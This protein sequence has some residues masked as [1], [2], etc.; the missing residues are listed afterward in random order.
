MR[1]RTGRAG[2][3]VAH[4]LPGYRFA[5]EVL[6]RDV[7]I[8]T[9]AHL[10]LEDLLNVARVSTSLRSVVVGE[11]GAWAL[12]IEDLAYHAPQHA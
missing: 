2:E 5:L 4:G 9:L 10:P 11:A 6:S 12:A 3:A 8:L 1:P 7:L